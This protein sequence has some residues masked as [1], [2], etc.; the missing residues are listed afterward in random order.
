MTV[1]LFVVDAFT[2]VPFAGNPAAVCLLDSP[3]P[4]SWLQAVAREMNL[5]ETAFV[6]P[7]GDGWLLRWFTP[8]V[9]VDLC[10][11]ATLACAHVMWER[12]MALPGETIRFSTRS[13][14]L[15][16]DWDAELIM[17]DFPAEPALPVDAC[18]DPAELLGVPA[19]V[20]GKNR[21]DYLVEVPDEEALLGVQPDLA[22]LAS[23]SCRGMI[24]TCRSVAA[25]FD[26]ASRFFAPAVGVPEDPVTGSAHCCLAPYWAKKLGKT[27]MVGRQDSARGGIVMVE[28]AGDRVRLGGQACTI[29]MGE[30]LAE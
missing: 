13:G 9:E 26:F 1:P 17:L 28:V 16:A 4:D 23:I 20:A 21:M 12:K 30:L 18:F 22:S 14:Q 27:R 25:G 15:A 19:F 10:G 3:R 29:A 2:D 6:L 11:H 7:E 8:S 5:S 24:V